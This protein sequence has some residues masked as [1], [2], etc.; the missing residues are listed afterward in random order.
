MPHFQRLLHQ[1][2]RALDE[3]ERILTAMLDT[4][5]HDADDLRP[6]GQSFEEATARI[7][8]ATRRVST[9]HMTLV[10]ALEDARSGAGA[11]SAQMPSDAD[12]AAV[13]ERRRRLADTAAALRDSLSQRRDRM[14]EELRNV[15]RPRKPRSIYRDGN[16][17]SMIDVSG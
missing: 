3:Y 8:E 2:Q 4:A 5:G 1:E 12:L 7:D 14:S 15:R 17:P 9:C 6:L 10:R 11:V 16:T 13:D